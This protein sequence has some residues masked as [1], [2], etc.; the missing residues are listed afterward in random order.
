[1]QSFCGIDFG[2]SNS[3]IGICD[4]NVCQ[5]VPLEHNQPTIRSAIFCD[6][7]L[8]KLEF[9]QDAINHYLEGFPGRLMMALKSV[10]T[11]SLMQ[12]NTVIFGESV[13]YAHI[14]GQFIKY[15]KNQAEKS[16][17]GELTQVVMGRPVHFHDRNLEK[18]QL[19]QNTL[20]SI[21]RE[22]GFKDIIFQ[23]E[24]IAAALTYETTIRKEQ[25]AIIVDMGGGTS[26]FTVIRLHP[27]LVTRDRKEDVLAT[28]G[29]HIAGT[30]FDKKLSM[31]SVMP[32][33]GL[34]SLM[35]GSSSDIEVPAMYYH[36][37]TTWHTLNQLYETKNIAHVQGIQSA[38]HDKHL[39]ENLLRVLKNRAGHHILNTVEI[40]KQRLSDEAEVKLDLEFIGDELSVL[41]ARR[42][43]D[44]IIEEPL[45]QIVSTINET[46]KN[47]KCQASDIN[48]VFFTGGSTKIPLI[49][50]Q[51]TAMFPKAEVVHGDAFGSVGLGLT[52]QAQRTFI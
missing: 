35:R 45:E 49:R 2:T 15:I 24:P 47:A 39:I 38:A 42:Q 17:G 40:G 22:L 33:L 5:L 31:Y 16:F 7:E 44:E 51:I 11:T 13:S 20:E 19:A 29:I 30:D 52:L 12:D 48:A 21:A 8:K 25:L 27:K 9:G 28:G 32:L 43:L 3:T 37:L 23:F 18:D 26:D 41:V 36:D 14:L 4:N 10:L 46:L 6:N 50:Q 34:G 1:M